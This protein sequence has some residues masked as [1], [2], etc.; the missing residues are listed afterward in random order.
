MR[1]NFFKYSPL[2]SVDNYDRHTPI[3]F[4]CHSTI[5]FWLKSIDEVCLHYLK[6][7]GRN[8]RRGTASLIRINSAYG[9]RAL[10]QLPW[11]H[12]AR[13]TS[14]ML[15]KTATKFYGLADVERLFSPINSI[16]SCFFGFRYVL[17][18][19]KGIRAFPINSKAFHLSKSIGG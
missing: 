17:D 3:A 9:D 14:D 5:S 2:A 19:I 8:T 11:S 7:L 1:H 6:L 13:P 10:L 4:L 16:Y 12:N 15:G 18:F